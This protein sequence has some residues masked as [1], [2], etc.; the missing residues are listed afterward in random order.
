MFGVYTIDDSEANTPSVN[1][2]STVLETLREQ[3]ASVQEQHVFSPTVLNTV[4]FGYSRAGYSFT[5]ETAGGLPGWVQGDP[6]GAVVI[7][8]GTAL[9]GA[10]A[11][12][13]AGTNATSNLAAVRNLFTYDDHIA[14]THGIHQIEAGVWVQRIQANDNL[15]QYQFGQASFSSLS[16]FLQGTVGTFTVVPSATPLGWRSV[17]TAAFVQDAIRLT[18]HLQLTLGFRAEGTNGWNEVHN[19]ASTYL[20]NSAGVIET[21]PQV[22]SSVFSVNR[23]KFLPEP[24]AGLAWD[25]TGRSKTVIHAGFGIYRAL[26]ENIDYRVD[27]AAPYNTTQT[28]KNVSLANLLFVPGAPINSSSLISPSGIQPDSYTPTVLSWTFK[29]EQQ[30]APN[31]SLSVGYVGSH[32]YHEMLSVDANE[33]FP[34]YTSTGAI[35]YPKG[36]TN[37]NPALANT[38]TYFSEGVSSYNALQVDVN[39]RF[40]HGLQIRGV[41]TWSKNLDDGTAWNSSVAS[42]APGFVMFP[43]NPKIDYGPATDNIPNLA[44]LNG[45]Y[46]L[47][48]GASRAGWSK[49]LISGWSTSAIVTLESGLPFT[50]QLG[51]NGTGNGDSRNPIRPSYNP[52]FTGPI[53]LGG[54]NEYFN[55][56]A[57]VTPATGTYGNVGRD[58]LTGPGLHTIDF[59][60]TKKTALTERVNLQ[61]RAEF[62][63]IFNNVNFSTPNAVVYTAA[64]TTPSPTAGV[65]TAT[66]STSRQIQFGLKLLF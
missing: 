64:G 11:I 25:P 56:D 57:F 10:S 55:P 38:T 66:A 5:G 51:Y 21:T 9:N 47:P 19:R 48:F 39:R 22:G 13:L 59:S 54:P 45:T 36:V 31:T 24:R 49:K 12:S 58:T 16:S 65:I 29:V 1:P 26:L 42:N 41:Y 7:G 53:V 28:I 61:F 40:S 20:F 30:I 2:L 32:G 3:V 17:E 60:A 27:G 44:V 23:A 4:R 18:S 8:G 63:N 33:P 34:S 62:F 52:N 14:I 50:A 46:E 15:A 43:L 6:I 35:F 37:A